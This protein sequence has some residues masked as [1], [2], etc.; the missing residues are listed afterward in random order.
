M[1]TASP[2]NRLIANSHANVMAMSAIT[3]G[4]LN[5]VE[6]VAV[7]N[8]EASRAATEFYA[9]RLHM[10]KGDDPNALPAFQGEALRS[11]SEAAVAYFRSVQAISSSVGGEVTKVVS[12]RAGEATDAIV[13]VL[14][15]VERSSPAPVVAVVASVKSA[16]ANT[17]AAYESM[18]TTGLRVAEGQAAQAAGLADAIGKTS[19]T[20]KTSKA[21]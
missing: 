11:A 4:M 17:R 9:N 16:V 12:A 19:R 5:A 21:G 18:L 1:T 3:Q 14:E 8:I 6:R 7:L 15:D 20:R 2:M 13:A 10:I